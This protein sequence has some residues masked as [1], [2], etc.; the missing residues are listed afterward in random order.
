MAV[1]STVKVSELEGA[2]RLDAEHYKPGDLKLTK[3]LAKNLPL[4]A[5]VEQIIH[6]VE[7]KRAYEDRGIRVVLAQNVRQ[8]YLDLSAEFFMP[9]TVQKIIGRN[10]LFSGDVLATRTGANYGDAAP[11]FGD[12]P[13]LYACADV[14][15]IRPKPGLKSGY[16]STFLNTSYGR[17]LTK[18]GGYSGG[19]PH[20]AP[21]FLR[22]LPLPRFDGGLEE[23]VEDLVRAASRQFSESESLYLDAERLVL[24]SL[25]WGRVQLRQPKAYS[26]LLSAARDI[27]RLDAEYFQPKYE[28]LISYLKSIGRTRPLGAQNS[29]IKRGQQPSY[30]GGGD[31]L[32]VNS[33]HLGRCFVDVA[34]TE[35]TDID[36][37][38]RNEQS[39]LRERDVLMYSTGAYLGRTNVW[40]ENGKAIA[41]NHV[42]VIRPDDFYD[43]I[44]LAVFLNSPPGL[45]Q[46]ERWASGSGQREIYPEN[47]ACIEIPSLGVSLQKKVADQVMRAYHVRQ[48]AVAT[49]E[50]AKSLLESLIAPRI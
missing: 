46:S 18:R 5:Y 6:P 1:W 39:R 37:W 25:S 49:L 30:I 31:V 38:A 48:S 34:G 12:P 9:A 22:T 3:R 8:N 19:Q 33:Q 17:D 43:P 50:K 44:Y 45:L 16:L 29:Y 23:R 10:Q 27:K 47:I 28:T 35:R 2:R 26:V 40:L 14:L 15:I 21:N 7:I 32:V 41:S 42:T 36:F 24:E 13:S 11:Y 20:I 4:G